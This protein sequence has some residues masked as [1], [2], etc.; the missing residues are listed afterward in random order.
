MRNEGN[1]QIEEYIRK[2]IGLDFRD[3]GSAGGLIKGLP[4]YL[5]GAFDYSFVDID[6]Q[7]FLLLAPSVEVDM[8]TAQIVKFA[9][10]IEKLTGK[11]TLIQFRSMDYIKRRTLVTG[12]VNFVVVDKQIYIPSLRTYLNE[13][14]SA[15]DVTAKETLSPAAQFLLLYHLQIKSLE[16]MPF[17]EMADVLRYSAK[18]ITVVVAELQ[19]RSIC[20]VVQAEGR[21]KVLRFHQKGR[22]LWDGVSPAMTT[23]IHKVW[24]IERD[25]LPADLPLRTS[26]DTALAHYTFM[27][28]SR[29]PAYAIDKRAFAGHQDS[30]SPFLHPE[31]GNVRLEVWKYDPALL[32]EGQFVDKLS[33]SLCYKETD[34]ERVRSEITRMIDKIEW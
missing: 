15:Q 1:C 22:E 8:P 33:L 25:A 5:K 21:N 34:D 16:N 31:E 26:Y 2:T 11:P 17:K 30:L 7:E 4:E 29:R 24:Y 9:G 20:D 18:T 19:S 14:G 12:R 10:Q 27:A 32:S 6:G 28:D 23:P 13:S 3:K